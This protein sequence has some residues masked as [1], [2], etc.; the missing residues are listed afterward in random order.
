MTMQI[1]DIRPLSIESDSFLPT[2]YGNFR[3]R[4]FVGP[5]GKEHTTL[6][7]GEFAIFEGRTG[8]CVV[9]ALGFRTPI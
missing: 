6:Y 4:V 3:I 2:E 1:D 7:T 9:R 8:W 5:D